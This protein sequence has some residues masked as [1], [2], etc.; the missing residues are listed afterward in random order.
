VHNK[1]D[2]FRT[3][4]LLVRAHFFCRDQI[5][6]LQ[7]HIHVFLH[8][9]NNRKETFIL[10]EEQTVGIVLQMGPKAED[11]KGPWNPISFAYRFIIGVLAASYFVLVPIYMWLKDLV[12]PKGQPI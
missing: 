8:A 2:Y 7:R 11:V 10:R 12:T 1:P 6:L 3:T 4:F 5:E 9:A